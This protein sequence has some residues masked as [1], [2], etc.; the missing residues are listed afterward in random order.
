VNKQ[1]K[2]SHTHTPQ[3]RQVSGNASSADWRRRPVR[4]TGAAA[5]EDEEVVVVVV[6]V[7]AAAAAEAV[8]L[9]PAA[10]VLAPAPSWTTTP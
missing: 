3:C 5:E 7:G 1:T 9:A 10:A 6:V 8:A 4:P 2:K